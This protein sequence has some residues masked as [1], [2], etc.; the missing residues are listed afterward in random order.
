MGPREVLWGIYT[1]TDTDTPLGGVLGPKEHACAFVSTGRAS[2]ASGVPTPAHIATNSTKVPTR[3]WE[4]R[5]GTLG[6]HW[7]PQ[8]GGQPYHVPGRE[9]ALAQGHAAKSRAGPGAWSL[10]GTTTAHVHIHRHPLPWQRRITDDRMA[11]IRR[12]LT[13][14][15]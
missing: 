11:F 9:T 1:Q 8:G 15:Q 14:S 12:H 5:Q 10:L 4:S 3:G 7:P 13:A 6:W 2:L